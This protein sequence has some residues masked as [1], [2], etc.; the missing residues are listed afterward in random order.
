MKQERLL[1]VGQRRIHFFKWIRR[2]VQILLQIYWEYKKNNYCT[3]YTYADGSLIRH[4]CFLENTKRAT[5]DKFQ[6]AERD[7]KRNWKHPQRTVI[8]VNEVWYHILKYPEV[9]TNLNFV[10][11]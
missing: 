11:I 7:R 8:I 5:S 1:H 6:Q 3:V 10:M 2:V 4:D 9:I